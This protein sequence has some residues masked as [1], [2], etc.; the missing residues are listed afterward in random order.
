M[1]NYVL[2]MFPWVCLATMPLFYPFDWPMKI[3]EKLMKIKSRVSIRNLKLKPQE[4]DCQIN[5]N[6][7]ES[8]DDDNEYSLV[9]GKKN[10]YLDNDSHGNVLKE[11]TDDDKA[12]EESKDFTKESCEIA[13]LN[14][15]ENKHADIPATQEYRRKKITLYLIIFHVLTQAFLP[16]SHFITQVSINK[17]SLLQYR[18][19]HLP[20]A[21][22]LVLRRFL[23]LFY[24]GKYL[25]FKFISF[26]FLVDFIYLFVIM[27]TVL[28]L[29]NNF[30][31]CV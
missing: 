20:L 6:S 22:S 27:S 13:E 23:L 7:E 30:E 14:C 3:S 9:N 8:N 12:I 29:I 21:V 10:D 17:Y 18:D 31:F 15:K 28:F 1:F 2:G 26:Y 5:E 25:T 16:Y 11:I 19:Y 24:F 4:C